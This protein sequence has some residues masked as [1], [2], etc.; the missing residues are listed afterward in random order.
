MNRH[1]NLHCLLPLRTLRDE[2]LRLSLMCENCHFQTQ[3]QNH[4]E[5]SLKSSQQSEGFSRDNTLL[6]RAFTSSELWGEVAQAKERHCP[7]ITSFCLPFFFLNHSTVSFF[8]P[9]FNLW[10]AHLRAFT[11]VS[12]PNPML[13]SYH[14]FS[15]ALCAIND[16]S[17]ETLPRLILWCQPCAQ[18]VIL[19]LMCVTTI[20]SSSKSHC[21]VSCKKSVTSV[22][23]NLLDT[24]NQLADFLNCVRQISGTDTGQQTSHWETLS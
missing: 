4:G 15:Y 16:G 1:S 13:I 23:L 10:S 8:H 9:M 18:N 17:D 19:E 20:C 6:H 11:T 22:F 2:V 24:R 12:L 5:M 7:L 3:R 21:Y 14:I